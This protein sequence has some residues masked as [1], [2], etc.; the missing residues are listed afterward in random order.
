MINKVLS[1]MISYNGHDVKR[2]NHALKVFAFASHISNCENCDDK[3][4]TI[5]SLASI[6]HDIGIHEAERIYKSTAGKHQ[7]EL[8]PKIAQKLIGN[9]QIPDEI[10][11]R[12]YYLIS[13]HHSYD[14]IDAKDFQILVEADFLVNIFEDEMPESAI[15]S[16]KNK[17]FKTDSGTELLNSMYLG[18]GNS[19]KRR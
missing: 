15:K 9:L 2:I 10:K 16:I 8:G 1:L 7:E 5:I 11:N 18:G 19:K 14:K 17:I 12:V 13:N 3:T 4:K 6:L